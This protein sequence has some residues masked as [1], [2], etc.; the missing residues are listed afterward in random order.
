METKT[1]AGA[2]WVNPDWARQSVAQSS[3]RVEKSLSPLKWRLCP[4]SKEN[5]MQF[6][7]CSYEQPADTEGSRKDR[8]DSTVR[9]QW[10]QGVW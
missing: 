3:N 2:G 8:C 4:C 5:L 6:V 9:S 1:I 10:S 7:S